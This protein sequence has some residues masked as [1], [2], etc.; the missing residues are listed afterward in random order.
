MGGSLGYLWCRHCNQ[1][2]TAW[3]HSSMHDTPTCCIRPRDSRAQSRTGLGTNVPSFCSHASCD[4]ALRGCERGCGV[5]KRMFGWELTPAAQRCV[6]CMDCVLCRATRPSLGGH[7]SGGHC[8]CDGVQC[9]PR[10]ELHVAPPL[11]GVWGCRVVSGQALYISSARAVSNG[12]QKGLPHDT[13]SLRM[14]H[15][16][17]PR[18]APHTLGMEVQ[19]P[20]QYLSRRHRHP[21]APLSPLHGHGR[22]RG[23]RGRAGVVPLQGRHHPAHALQVPLPRQHMGQAVVQHGRGGAHAPPGGESGKKG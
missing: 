23:R 12:D 6:H 17:N 22:R 10:L 4:T 8:G 7:G 13:A 15:P 21:R 11:R 5:T 9:L 1:K 20:H 16:V 2:G 18:D 14:R 3:V 19:S